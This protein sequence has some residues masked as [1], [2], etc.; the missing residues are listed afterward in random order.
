MVSHNV[1]E[2]T[3]RY[4]FK[5]WCIVHMYYYL[6]QKQPEGKLTTEH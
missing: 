3:A 5:S 4:C 1:T 2:I 6:L